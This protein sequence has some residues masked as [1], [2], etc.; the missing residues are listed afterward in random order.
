V[1]IITGIKVRKNLSGQ[2]FGIL[3]AIEPVKIEGKRGIFYRCKC[4]C[5]RIAIPFAA[6]L[7][8]GRAKSCRCLLGRPKHRMNGTP[9]YRA[10]YAAR[11]RCTNKYW[12][13]HKNYAGRGVEFKFKSF[14]EFFDEIGRRPSKRHSVDRINTNGHYETGNIRWATARQQCLNKTNNRY[15]TAYGKTQTVSEWAEEL[16]ICQKRISRRLHRGFDGTEAL[17]LKGLS[18]PLY[19]LT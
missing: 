1:K 10:Y 2:S 16:G 4:E 12:K 18:Y 5:G 3:T 11:A 8:R 6:D 14:Q 17:K 15:I 19:P 9:E 7:V 13:Q